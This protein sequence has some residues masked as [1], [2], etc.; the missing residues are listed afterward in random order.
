MHGDSREAFALWLM[1][2]KPAGRE[3]QSSFGGGSLRA[4]PLFSE[5]EQSEQ[6]SRASSGTVFFFSCG[7]PILRQGY[8]E[9]VPKEAVVP[10]KPAL[11]IRSCGSLAAS[12]LECTDLLRWMGCESSGVRAQETHLPGYLCRLVPALLGAGK[13]CVVSM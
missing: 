8:M 3:E 9:D 10:R 1:K 11:A 2:A 12:H 4:A 5:P 7:A 6:K 13:G